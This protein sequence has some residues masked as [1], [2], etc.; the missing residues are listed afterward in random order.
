MKKIMFALALAGLS[1]T[2]ASAQE[3][4]EIPTDKY[5]VATNRFG[6][7]WFITIGGDYTAFY[8]SQESGLGLST[9]PFK[10]FRRSWGADVAFGKWFTPALG[11]RFKGQGVWGKSVDGNPSTSTDQ[12]NITGQALLNLHNLFGGYKPNR[13]WNISFYLGAG[14]SRVWDPSSSNSLMLTTGLYNTFRLTD[15]LFIQ[16]DIYGNLGEAGMDGNSRTGSHKLLRNR[17]RSAGV[18]LGLGVNLGKTGWSKTPDVDAIM[19]LNKSQMDALNA[20]LA[21][22]EAEN[23]RLKALLA[24]QPKETKPVV[25]KVKE[26]VGTSASVFFNINSS[27]I[28]SKKDLVNVKEMVEFAKANNRKIVVKGY[29]DSNTGSAEYNKRLSERRAE[30]VANQLVEMGLSRDQIIVEAMGG[31]KD[32][33]PISYNRRATVQVK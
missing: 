12:F 6:G 21:D 13:V 10:S 2:S 31:V 16:L 5:S 22:Q 14:M 18:S 19:A 8:S 28:A 4:N 23:A 29:A 17:D 26:Y 9:N 3:W 1:A 20:S 33:T 32:L 15:R 11:L 30:T 7:N 27:R 24:K 25:E